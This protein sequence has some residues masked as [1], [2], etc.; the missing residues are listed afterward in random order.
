VGRLARYRLAGV[1]DGQ[2]G[3]IGK[4]AGWQE[5]QVDEGKGLIER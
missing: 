5:G 2:G 1:A 4:V 3:Q